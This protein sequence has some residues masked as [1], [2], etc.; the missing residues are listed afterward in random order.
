MRTQILVEDLHPTALVSSAVSS[1]LRPKPALGA[2]FNH[3]GSCLRATEYLGREPI[4]QD[5][6]K[7]TLSGPSCS[8]RNIM[9]TDASGKAFMQSV[10]PP[11]CLGLV[12]WSRALSEV[13]AQGLG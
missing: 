1:V 4:S 6:E 11:G 2:C 5:R 3:S 9:S 10:G 7:Y 8:S 13:P 12:R